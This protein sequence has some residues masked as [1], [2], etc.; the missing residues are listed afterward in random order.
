[1]SIIYIYNDKYYH[2]E[3]IESII[4]K[5]KEII[6]KKLI[7]PKFYLNI[8]PNNSFKKY[9]SDKY[10]NIIF[11]T[12]KNYD[13]YIS[14]TIYPIDFD[15]IN[16]NSNN[17]YYISHEIS[18]ELETLS[19][20]Y[21]LTPLAKNFLYA[22]ILPFTK[23]KIETN[24]PIY[25]IQGS[26]DNRRHLKLLEL[27]LSHKYKHDFKIKIVTKSKKIPKCLEKHKEKIIF[28]SNLNFIDFH[29]EFLDCYC[30]LPLISKET[31]NHYYTT[32]LTSSINYARGYNLTCLID[33]DLQNI[34]NLNNAIVYNNEKDVVQQFNK[35]L[36]NFY[37]TQPLTTYKYKKLHFY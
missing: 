16:H 19:N 4:V 2:Y 17:H 20:V 7:E 21:F 33:K 18:P 9:I 26:I 29:K 5:Y 30:I 24:F 13:Y 32:K 34:Y 25:I 36:D 23:Q 15:K 6:K 31:H 37:K 22:D 10:K 28:K 8:K 3:I 1:M 27:I 12:P 14:A 35:T 11:E